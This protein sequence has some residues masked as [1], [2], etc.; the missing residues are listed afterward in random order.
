MENCR[1]LFNRNGL[2]A[3][4]SLTAMVMSQIS[5]LEFNSNC[6]PQ[7]VIF[8]RDWLIRSCPFHLDPFHLPGYLSLYVGSL[9]E[10]K[11]MNSRGTSDSIASSA[12]ELR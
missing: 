8:A 4:Q 12:E 7:M 6:K 3:D 11:D 2:V 9:V 10:G 5:R 1:S